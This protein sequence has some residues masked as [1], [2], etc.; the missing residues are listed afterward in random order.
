M[1]DQKQVLEAASTL[2]AAFAANDTEAYFAAFS[3]DASF[4]FHTC[5]APLPTRAA[6]RELWE[7]WQRDGFEVL[8]CQSINPVVCLQGDVAIFY[9]DVATRLRIQGEEIESRERETIV[10]R[11]QQEKGHWLACHEHLS[12]MPEQLPQT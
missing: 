3:E 12:A 6:Y 4:V 5:D 9:H 2:V 7:S 8:A 1:S 10:F 11:R